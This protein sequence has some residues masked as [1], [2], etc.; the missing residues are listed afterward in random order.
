MLGFAVVLAISAASMGFAYLGFEGVSSGVAAY[1]NS[2]AEA[3][4]AR[5]IDRE[6]ISYRGLARY[7][8]VTGKEDDSK[9]AL[10]AQANLK[11]AIDQAMSRTRDTARLDGLKRLAREFDNFAATFADILKLNAENAHLVQ[12]QLTRGGSALRQT[13][14][15]IANTASEELLPEVESSAKQVGAQYLSMATLANTFVLNSDV[16]VAKTALAGLKFVESSLQAIPTANA[17]VAPGVKEANA[18]LAAYREALSQLLEN[19]QTIG[20]LVIQMNGSASAIM[21]GAGA[22][23][24][25]LVSDQQRLEAESDAAIVQTEHLIMMLAGRRLPARRGAG[26][27]AGQG[28]LAADDGDVQGDART[29]RRQFRRR[30]AGPRPQGRSRRDGRGGRGVQAAGGRQGRAR[31]RGPG[32]A[33]QGQ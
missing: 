12:N 27:L 19:V 23:K 21:Q 9:A 30:A 32:S 8:V 20:D 11:Q 6:L 31:C 18:M 26:D 4:L 14:D 10:A 25:D 1:R 16:P 22:M 2:V 24:A 7:Y 29:R 33:E 3:D 5:N 17:K 13:L 15:D 28:H